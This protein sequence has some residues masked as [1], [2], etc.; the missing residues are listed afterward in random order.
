MSFDTDY[1][2]GLSEMPSMS[3]PSDKDIL[4]FVIAYETKWRSRVGTMNPYDADPYARVG[5]NEMSDWCKANKIDIDPL[6]DAAIVQKALN[7]MFAR[8]RREY[9]DERWE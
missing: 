4:T 5:R 7:K 8:L 1:G 9:P 3:R 2:Q 6:L